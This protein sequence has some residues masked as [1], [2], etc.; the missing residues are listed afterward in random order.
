M[1]GAAR[2][3]QVI[4]HVSLIGTPQQPPT[5]PP[6]TTGAS[7]NRG[8]ACT[9]CSFFPLSSGAS[10]LPWRHEFRPWSP[11]NSSEDG[12]GR[13]EFRRQN[14]LFRGQNLR[15]WLING[16]IMFRNRRVTRGV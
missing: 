4:R 10:I 5:G 11:P 16:L 15:K 7:S 13:A 1:P 2:D 12:P 9:V 14:R 8:P 6:T 3:V